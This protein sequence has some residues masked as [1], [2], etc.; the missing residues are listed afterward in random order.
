MENFIQSEDY[1][2]GEVDPARVTKAT[3]AIFSS[4]LERGNSTDT[5]VLEMDDL[6]FQVNLAVAPD[7]PTVDI[8]SIDPHIFN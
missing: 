7:L 6:N 1:H 4:F 8:D 3:Q 5:R 2:F